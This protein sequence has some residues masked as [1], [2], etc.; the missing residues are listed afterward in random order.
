MQV[1]RVQRWVMSALVLTTAT[2]FATGISL[3]SGRS[4]QAGAKP[5]L[6]SM[7]VVV[8]LVAL[9]AVRVINQKRLVTPWLALA[10]LP[11]ALVWFLVV[12]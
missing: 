1:E 8:E 5:G 6:L 7:A 4:E 10:V 3:L 9:V 2:I 12:R 11:A